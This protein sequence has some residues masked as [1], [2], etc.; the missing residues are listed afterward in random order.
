MYSS[1]GKEAFKSANVETGAQP[2]M[3]APP[4]KAQ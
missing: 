1:L 2:P 3:A 4:S